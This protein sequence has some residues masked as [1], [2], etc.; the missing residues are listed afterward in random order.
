M[1]GPTSVTGQAASVCRVYPMYMENTEERSDVVPHR[2][3]DLGSSPSPT[4]CCLGDLG[5]LE[6]DPALLSRNVPT[7]ERKL[8]FLEAY[9]V[10]TKRVV[11]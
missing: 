5:A 10:K 7:Q 1:I 8:S 9:C 6:G 11:V 4:P 2:Q 3:T